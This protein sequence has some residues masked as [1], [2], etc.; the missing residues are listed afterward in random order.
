MWVFAKN[1]V[2]KSMI[3]PWKNVNNT[4][5]S[6]RIVRVEEYDLTNIS[7]KKTIYESYIL[8]DILKFLITG[9]QGGL[10]EFAIPDTTKVYNVV[11]WNGSSLLVKGDDDNQKI[12]YID[13]NGKKSDILYASIS[14]SDENRS[15][16]PNREITN[17]IKK[18][19]S[20]F[21]QE[22][23]FTIKEVV[24]LMLVLGEMPDE[25]YHLLMDK[26]D[27]DTYVTLI[28]CVN[29]LTIVS[30]SGQDELVLVAE[31]CI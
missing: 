9:K 11:I 31:E 10:K 22:A 2:Y 6:T 5:Y 14:F 3:E 20:S 26:G 24:K 12:H 15:H 28:S 4:V 27:E 13:R 21:T 25:E 7:H 1:T 19:E 18:Y 8:Y 29:E 17:F 23:A 30:L 16:P